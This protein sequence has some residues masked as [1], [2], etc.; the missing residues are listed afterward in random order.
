[1]PAMSQRMPRAVPTSS[2]ASPPQRTGTYHW[3]LDG[4]NQVDDVGATTQ[5][6]QNLHLTFYLLFLHWLK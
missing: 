2:K 3:I 4:V 1:M 6:L 5:V